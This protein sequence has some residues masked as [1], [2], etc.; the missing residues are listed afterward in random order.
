MSCIQ[1]EDQRQ[2]HVSA[3]AEAINKIY[4][5]IGLELSEE[6]NIYSTQMFQ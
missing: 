5:N 1:D 4:G 3:I 6:K 2:R